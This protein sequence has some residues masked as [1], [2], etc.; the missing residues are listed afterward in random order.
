MSL[1]DRTFGIELEYECGPE[2]NIDVGLGYS[3]RVALYRRQLDREPPQEADR[4]ADLLQGAGLR[5]AAT[6]LTD[7]RRGAWRVHAEEAGGL[8]VNSPIL[9]GEDGL[10]SAREAVRVLAAAGCRPADEY[11]LHVH[12]GAGDLRLH[13]VQGVLSAATYFDKALRALLPRDRAQSRFAAPTPPDAL[14]AALRAKDWPGFFDA[15][16]SSRNRVLNVNALRRHGTL[17]LRCAP[18][19]TDGDD[20]EG[21]VRIALALVERGRRVRFWPLD[22][23]ADPLTTLLGLPP[24]RP[25]RR[26]VLGRMRAMAA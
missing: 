20:L 24:V 2:R 18:S 9:R 1:P 3:G 8:E 21:W 19:T 25:S 5:A 12:V 22:R 16:G 6:E 10:Q 26:W 23:N 4:L 14:D 11:G 7:T 17:E 15:V 13:E